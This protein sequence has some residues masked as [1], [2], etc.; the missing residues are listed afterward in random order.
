MPA[1]LDRIV[2]DDLV[3]GRIRQIEQE[4]HVEMIAENTSQL[5]RYQAATLRLQADAAA[6]NLRAMGELA[7]RQDQTN[8]YLGGMAQDL[9]TMV[10]GIDRL[11]TGMDDLNVTAEAT[12][13]SINDMSAML[14]ES[15]KLISHQIMQQQQVLEAIAEMLRRPYETRA[16]ELRREAD[17]WLTNG[18][19]HTGRDRD[20]DWKDAMRLLRTTT[21]NPIGMQDYVAWF[22]IGWLLWKHTKNVPEAEEAFYRAQRLSV[23]NADLYHEK[24]VRHLAYMQYLQSKYD[25]AYESIQKAIKVSGSHDTLFDAARYAAKV[26]RSKES[27]E[28]LSRCIDLQPTT[29]ITMFAEEDFQE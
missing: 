25:E 14:G 24:S 22:Q 16:L 15:L 4:Y 12:L 27:S 11:N 10:R 13:S 1:P 20:E 29:I 9:N 6:T 5:V 17:R 3:P 28:F 19:R 26:G 18:M 7:A 2:L 21:E 8:S 23:A